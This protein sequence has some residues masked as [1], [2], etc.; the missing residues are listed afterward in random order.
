MFIFGVKEYRRLSFFLMA[1]NT[2]ETTDTTGLRSAFNEFSENTTIYADGDEV[3]METTELPNHS[4]PY[5]SSDHAL[6][7]VPTV[8]TII[9]RKVCFMKIQSH[10]LAMRAKTTRPEL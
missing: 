8:T 7:V 6:Y 9:K 3:V 1:G 10:L 4:S 2:D 5:W